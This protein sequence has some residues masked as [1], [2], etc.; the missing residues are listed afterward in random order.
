MTGV[1]IG[2]EEL[3]QF[4]H[5]LMRHGLIA[6]ISMLLS[7]IS[8]PSELERIVR[9]SQVLTQPVDSIQPKSVDTAVQ[10]KT[11]DVPHGFPHGWMLPIEIG[12]LLEK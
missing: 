12:L 4:L 8:T 9:P 7:G 5:D 11:R 6:V 1:R 3:T 10:P 2:G